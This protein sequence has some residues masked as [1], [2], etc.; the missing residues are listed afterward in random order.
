[1]KNQSKLI[2]VAFLFLLSAFYS[3]QAKAEEG[4]GARDAGLNPIGGG[5]VGVCTVA[6]DPTNVSLTAKYDLGFDVSFAHSG[7]K[8]TTGFDVSIQIGSAP[9][10][11]CSG[12][13]SVSI[14]NAPEDPDTGLRVIPL[15]GPFSPETEYFV[16]VCAVNCGKSSGA[17]SV[18]STTS[19][20]QGSISFGE[21][22]YYVSESESFIRMKLSRKNGSAGRIN[23]NLDLNG[24]SATDGVDFDNSTQSLSFAA[25]V[26]H[27]YVKVPIVKDN[28]KESNETFMASLSNVTSPDNPHFINPATG[29]ANI[30]IY[31]VQEESNNQCGSAT[32]CVLAKL[33]DPNQPNFRQVL[34][35]YPV[36]GDGSYSISGLEVPKGYKIVLEVVDT[37]PNLTFYKRSTVID[38]NI[39]NANIGMDST[40][41]SEALATSNNIEQ[42][43]QQLSAQVES[44]KTAVSAGSMTHGEFFIFLH[45]YKNSILSVFN[46]GDANSTLGQVNNDPTLSQ[47]TSSNGAGP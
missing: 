3:S 36:A 45:K 14:A 22:T 33:I 20:S 12:A 35:T 17:T 7:G 41:M 11:G 37:D 43:K 46:G 34:G 18:A 38:A 2:L 4:G 6:D 24:V 15:S 44:I 19:L 28:L 39:P 31:D 5:G 8:G 13:T 42:T 9:T 25:G 27:L 26:D 32:R 40:I 21:S 30:V 29:S 23:F 16:K 47:G 1:M 10:D